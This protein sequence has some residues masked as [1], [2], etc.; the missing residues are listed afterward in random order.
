MTNNVKT[1]HELQLEINKLQSQIDAIERQYIGNR[2][3]KLIEE[4]Y[5]LLTGVGKGFVEGDYYADTRYYSEIPGI[6]N[7]RLGYENEIIVKVDSPIGKL[8]PPTL[9]M[10]DHEFKLV[11]IYSTKY[12]DALDY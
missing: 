6:K 8:L 5:N 1:V 12:S 10:Q 3:P 9:K 7:I 2:M 11:I 4:V